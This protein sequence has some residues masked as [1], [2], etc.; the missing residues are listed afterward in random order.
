MASDS[1]ESE[2]GRERPIA[3]DL[4]AGAGG[5]SL[6]LEQAGFEIGVAIE[7]APG[8]AA[9]HRFNF[10]Y[11]PVISKD[12]TGVTASEVRMAVGNGLESRGLGWDNEITLC[13]GGPPCQGY[14]VGGHRRADDERNVLVHQFWRLVVKLK[15]R[16]FLMENVPGLLLRA[17]A[18]TLGKL[19][20]AFKRSGYH[21]AEPFLLDASRLGLPQ[22]RRRVLIIGWREGEKPVDI[23]ALQRMQ[24]PAVSVHE[25]LGDL[26]EVESVGSLI[27]TDIYISR[28][29]D[30]ARSEYAQRMRDL[31]LGFARPRVW[32]GRSL[33]GCCRTRHVP[34]VIRRFRET[35][36][37]ETEPVSRYRRL[38]SE[39][40]SP[41]LRAGTGPDHG[42][43]TPPRPIHYRTPRVITVREAAR[44][45]SFPDWFRF[46]AAKWHAW[47]EIGNAVPPLMARVVGEA[48]LNATGIRLAHASH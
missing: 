16:Y 31:A 29:N 1:F 18:P 40:I 7:K 43:H 8:P 41:T 3:V 11:T 32:D 5:L 37:G 47:Q 38:A 14:S 26:P 21:V 15:S 46:A 27:E 19:L 30:H 6:G 44:L 4:F 42:S 22:S 36:P 12:I 25:A 20:A 28:G 35:E 13:A 23:A 9:T 2:H 39:G 24:Y 34:E 33:S 10:P 17:N 48:V 45:Q